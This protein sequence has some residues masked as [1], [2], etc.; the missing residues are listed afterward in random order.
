MV[1][2][3]N[4]ANDVMTVE[5]RLEGTGAAEVALVDVQGRTVQTIAQG[6]MSGMQ[7]FSVNVDSLASG[8]YSVVVKQQGTVRAQTL[9]II[10]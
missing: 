9:R 1:V 6:E 5:V 4:P 8:T 3:P 7:R 2:T 10:K